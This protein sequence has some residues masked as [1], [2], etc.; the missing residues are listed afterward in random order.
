MPVRYDGQPGG[1]FEEC[2]PVVVHGELVDGTF[3][4]DRVEVKHSNEY[5]AENADRIDAAAG[6]V[7]HVLAASLNG[8]L[9]RAGLMLTLA[10]ATFGAMATVYGIRRGDR[11]HPAHGAALRLAVR[12]R[13]RA[14]RRDDAAGAD[15]PRLLA[16]LRPAGRLA[17]ARRRST[18]SP[19]CG[20]RSR[21]RS[22]CGS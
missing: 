2:Q 11:R 20:R 8:A 14:R 16:G 18:T 4:G 19:R 5:E 21:A 13:R 6:G 10:A 22:C 17:T 3:E 7:R 9:G 12:R 1:I 15:H